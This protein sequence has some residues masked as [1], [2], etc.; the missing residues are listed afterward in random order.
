MVRNIKSDAIALEVSL[1]NVEVKHPLVSP[2][3][4]VLYG[5]LMLIYAGR[6]SA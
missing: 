2:S 4:L 3:P 6:K 1:R 5:W